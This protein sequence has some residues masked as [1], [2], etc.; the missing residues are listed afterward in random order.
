M[1]PNDETETEREARYRR[2]GKA[3]A[4][5]IKN[6]LAGTALGEKL[7]ARGYTWVP[8]KKDSSKTKG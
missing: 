3:S 4:K 6:T 2:F 5:A 8:E 7:R 1:T